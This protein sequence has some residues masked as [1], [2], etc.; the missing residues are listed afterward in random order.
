MPTRPH[1]VDLET[2]AAILAEA[3]E[4]ES[5]VLSSEVPSDAVMKRLGAIEVEELDGTTIPLGRLWESRPA[6]VLFLRHYG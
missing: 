2:V 6:A 5:E 3:R 1:K 4:Q